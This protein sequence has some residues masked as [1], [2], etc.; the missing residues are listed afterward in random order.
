MKER[1]CCKK[2]KNDKPCLQLKNLS[3]FNTCIDNKIEFFKNIS[4][5]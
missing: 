4:N 3:C 1:V 2:L 5:K